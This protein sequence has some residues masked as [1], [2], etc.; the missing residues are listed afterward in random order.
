MY[1]TLIKRWLR[2]FVGLFAIKTKIDIHL[3]KDLVRETELLAF[4]SSAEFV[5]KH[6]LMARALDSKYM[7]LNHALSKLPPGK[8]GL[9]C[10]F[11]VYRGGTINHVAR[12]IKSKIYGFDSFQGLPEA[13]RDALPASTF[14][15]KANL[16]KVENNVELIAGWFDATLPGFVEKHPGPLMFLH[17]D[18]DLYSSTKTIFKFLGNRLGSGSVIVFDEYFNYPGWQQHEHLAFEEFIK[19]TGHRFE[20]LAYNRYSNQVAVQLL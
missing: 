18:C 9:Y 10:E 1:K 17:V 20:Y 3:G 12:Q 15:L 7:V 5:E 13:W 14:T 4:R 8:D 2:W 19:E 11:G 6:L 16:P